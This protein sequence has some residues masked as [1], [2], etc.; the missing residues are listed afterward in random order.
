MRVVLD[1][2]EEVIS[3]AGHRAVDHKVSRKVFLE[4]CLEGCMDEYAEL[5]KIDNTNLATK[6]NSNFEKQ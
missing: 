3:W 4:S 6:A 2:S 5:H 1:L